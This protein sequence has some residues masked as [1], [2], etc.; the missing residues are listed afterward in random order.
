MIALPSTCGHRVKDLRGKITGWLPS[1]DAAERLHLINSL[2]DSA[3][4][5][6]NLQLSL[7]HRSAKGTVHTTDGKPR[8]GRL[9]CNLD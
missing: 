1:T 5:P 4:K 9:D 3:A 7:A 8:K 6:A 2:P